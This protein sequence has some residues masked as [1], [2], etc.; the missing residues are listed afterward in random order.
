MPPSCSPRS[1]STTR[2]APA[3]RAAT[4]AAIPEGPPPMT[5][6][7]TSSVR[8]VSSVPQVF[9]ASGKEPGAIPLER[10]LRGKHTHLFF[11][12]LLNARAAEATLA[13]SHGCPGAVLDGGDG[14][15]PQRVVDGLQD[16]FAGYALTAADDLAVVG[17]FIHQLGLLL[18]RKF[19]KEHGRLPLG[20]ELAVGPQRQVGADP[21]GDVQGDGGGCG[22]ARR[23]N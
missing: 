1:M 16:F 22:E 14:L 18:W 5:A 4:A 3:F 6:T 8:I 2:S 9:G 13:A 21:R 10:H 17:V 15:G 12:Y 7:S 11:Q 23:L 20:M 19:V